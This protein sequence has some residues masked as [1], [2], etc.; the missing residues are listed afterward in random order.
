MLNA[1]LDKYADEGIA[2]LE[3]AKILK[4]KPFSDIGTPVEIINKVF[5]GKDRY[6][7]AIQELEREL[8]SLSCWRGPG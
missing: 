2:S 5:G 8:F 4:L 6:E 3:N 7:T 1:L